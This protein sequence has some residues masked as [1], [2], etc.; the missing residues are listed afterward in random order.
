MMLGKFAGV[1]LE[2]N[3]LPLEVSLSRKIVGT[4]FGVCAIRTPRMKV[5]FGRC[6]KRLPV[7]EI[8]QKHGPIGSL[9][10]LVRLQR[11]LSVNHWNPSSRLSMRHD[12]P[13]SYL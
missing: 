4:S 1:V 12:L 13:A 5:K 2:S 9:V 6:F 11:M 3:F 10:I 7:F 8:P